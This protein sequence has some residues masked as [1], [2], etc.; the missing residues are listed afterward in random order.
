[1]IKYKT[2][3]LPAAA[4][5]LGAICGGAPKRKPKSFTISASRSARRS[6]SRTIGSTPS[7]TPKKPA[8]YAEETLPAGEKILARVAH[9]FLLNE[10]DRS[11]FLDVLHGHAPDKVDRLLAMMEELH[12]PQ[13]TEQWS[14]NKYFRM[15]LNTLESMEGDDAGKNFFRGVRR[16][17]DGTQKLT[18]TEVA[19][20]TQRATGQDCFHGSQFMDA[21]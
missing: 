8:K 14:R 6:R 19:R 7:V 20:G 2:A 12:I 3:V 4:M 10:T 18:P 5:Q 17:V 21:E 9:A 15:A 13:L 1:M 11:Q 16:L